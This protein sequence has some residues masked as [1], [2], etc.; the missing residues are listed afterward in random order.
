MTESAV[1]STVEE[2]GAV[3]VDLGERLRAIRRLRRRTLKE[4]ASAA[5]ISESFLSQLERGRTNATIATLQRLSA[6]PGLEGSRLFPTKAPPPPA[7]P[8]GGR[9]FRALGALG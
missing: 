2:D 5:G 7:F 8:P 3:H 6:G 4:V 1:Q 9:E